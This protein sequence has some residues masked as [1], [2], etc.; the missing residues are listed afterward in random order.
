MHQTL[1]KL[2]LLG[3]ILVIVGFGLEVGVDIA[4]G[5]WNN[6]PRQT[7]I[8]ILYSIAAFLAIIPGIWLQYAKQQAIS[9]MHFI[10]LSIITIVILSKAWKFLAQGALPVNAYSHLAALAL[11]GAVTELQNDA[12]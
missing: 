4:Q 7:V 1:I 5:V 12:F 11:W 10:L 2:A 8:L 6:A 9:S 3:L